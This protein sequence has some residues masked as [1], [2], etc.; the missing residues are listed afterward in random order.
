[1]KKKSDSFL[2]L[3]NFRLS[4]KAQNDL[5]DASKRLCVPQVRI[6]EEL[7]KRYARSLKIDFRVE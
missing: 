1:M 6:V 3:K 5:R 7:I 4:T 2:K